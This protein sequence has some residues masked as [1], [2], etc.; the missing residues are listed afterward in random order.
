MTKRLLAGTVTT[1]LLAALLTAAG[2]A[3]PALACACGAPA[4]LVGASVSVGEEHA[5]VT[6]DGEIE[7]IEMTLDMLTEAAET[8]LVVPTPT[9]ATVS[10]GDARLFTAL[11]RQTAP[12]EIV[13]EDWWSTSEDNLNAGGAP[14][15]LSQV[16]LGPITAV[17]LSASDA[18]G[19]ASWLDENGYGID[20]AVR[21][22][23]ADY[24]DRGW[25]FAAL[26][27]AGEE[28][29]DG[30]LDPVRFDFATSEVVYPLLL[31][32]LSP[33]AQTVRLYLFGADGMQATFPDGTVAGDVTWAGPVTQPSLALL[34][35]YLTVVEAHFTEPA[36]QITGDLAITSTGTRPDHIPTVTRTKHV[37]VGG[38]PLGIAIV[39]VGSIFGLMVVLVVVGAIIHR[40]G[41][42]R[43][44]RMLY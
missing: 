15:V 34:G 2:L 6:F 8:G 35:D 33:R 1:A 30:R 14:T 41:E 24:V 7:R 25:S 40:V 32:R 5:I 28:K 19:L 43:R 44:S 20:P 23:F 9:P 3:Q 36:A 18:E 12:A 26:K 27:L 11:D 4:P 22:L 10:L 21:E 17:T 37:E 13:S 42:R 16:D 31:S 29:L 39:G 38:I